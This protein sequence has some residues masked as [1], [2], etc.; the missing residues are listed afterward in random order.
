MKKTLCLFLSISLLT[1]ALSSCGNTLN[2]NDIESSHAS[3]ADANVSQEHIEFILQREV[4][5]NEMHDIYKSVVSDFD[6]YLSLGLTF[7]DLLNDK[8]FDNLKWEYGSVEDGLTTVFFYGIIKKHNNDIPIAITFTWIQDAKKPFIPAYIFGKT[9]D[10]NYNQWSVNKV[11]EEFGYDD[12]TAIIACDATFCAMLSATLINTTDNNHEEA[13]TTTDNSVHEPPSVP[14][15]SAEDYY[16]MGMDS[17]DSGSYLEAAEHFKNAGNYSDSSTMLLDCYYQY[18]KAQ[19]DL[20]YTSEGIKYLSMCRGHKDTDDILL[21]FYLSQAIDS[22]NNFL[23]DL[24]TSGDHSTAYQDAKQKLLLC[25]GYKDSTIMMRV[26]ECVYFAHKEMEVV[27]SW[28]ASLNEMSVSANG[29]DVS[30]KKEKF[31]GSDGGLN[32]NTNVLQKTFSASISRVF[33]PNMRNYGEVNVLEALILLF[34]AINDTT[35]L[36]SQLQNEN[37]WN[38]T[39]SGE[40][41]YCELGGYSIAIQVTVADRGYINCTISAYN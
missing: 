14:P 24:H 37:C 11:Q 10:G 20:N 7:R 32:L 1:V 25:E 33:A 17:Y 28:E 2:K 18:G 41:F 5:F 15:V 30:I 16:N 13:E 21:S 12:A 40:S 34:T 26:V 27:S 9:D 39:E 3:Q 23:Q 6:M 36:R 35:D 29:N 31:M 4:F 19:M 38:I 22:Y 8:Y